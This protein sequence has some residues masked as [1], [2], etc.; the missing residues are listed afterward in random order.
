VLDLRSGGKGE[1]AEGVGIDRGF[2]PADDADAT[3]G[4]HVF[5]HRLELLLAGGIVERQ[6]KDRHCEITLVFQRRAQVGGGLEED[7]VGN[8][9]EDAG[10]V[11][12]LHVGIDRAAVGHVADRAEGE[13]ED[14]IGAFAVDLGDGTHAAVVA[15]GG[16]AVEGSGDERRARVVIGI[17]RKEWQK[18]PCPAVPRS[19]QRGRN[20]QRVGVQT[21]AS[22][23]CQAGI[24]PLLV[25]ET[26]ESAMP[27]SAG[28]GGRRFKS[29]R[30]RSAAATLHS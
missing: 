2:V 14:L 19:S 6:E 22:G 13:F 8:L 7:R 26:Q 15:L 24:V 5:G 23:E 1:L 4:D 28:A 16:E 10:A 18:M 29:T 11:A 3:L 25:A 21:A 12:G 20:P 17:H 9:R 27:S 30:K